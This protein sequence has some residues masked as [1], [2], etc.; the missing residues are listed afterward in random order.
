MELMSFKE[1]VNESK[2]VWGWV[3]NSCI[4]FSEQPYFYFCRAVLIDKG[5]DY[6]TKTKDDID[7]LE[8]EDNSQAKTAFG[9]IS[10][11]MNKKSKN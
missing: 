11:F 8:F 9:V 4:Y 5:I 6:N 2:S 10:S 1:F 3:E 7:Y